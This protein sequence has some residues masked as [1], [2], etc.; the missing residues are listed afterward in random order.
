MLKNY[1]KEN[2]DLEVFYYVDP[3]RIIDD[4]VESFNELMKYDKEK[5]AIEIFLKDCP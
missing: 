3:M 4:P 5:T 2:L 1:G